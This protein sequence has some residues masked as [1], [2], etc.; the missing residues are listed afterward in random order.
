MLSRVQLLATPWTA[1]CRLFHPWDFPGKSTGVGC[2]CLLQGIFPTQALNSCLL[3]WKVQ[4]VCLFR[5]VLAVM[6]CRRCFHYSLWRPLWFALQA[7][8]CEQGF[9]FCL[10]PENWSMCV[11]LASSEKFGI[12]RKG[13]RSEAFKCWLC[14]LLAVQSWVNYLTLLTSVSPFLRKHAIKT[15]IMGMK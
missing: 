10:W 7:T 14:H 8:A 11:E 1:A 15:H 2:H 12:L 13:K 4:E 9:V 3:Y 5:P 6:F